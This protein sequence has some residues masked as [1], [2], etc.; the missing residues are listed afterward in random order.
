MSD[1]PPDRGSAPSGGP[2][3]SVTPAGGNVDAASTAATAAQQR[4]DRLAALPPG[5]L[6]DAQ[7][8][9][10]PRPNLGSMLFLTAF[11]FFMSGGNNMPETQIVVGPDGQIK[12]RVT[13][14]DMARTYVDEYKGWMNGTGNWTEVET[15]VLL[16]SSIIP[17]EYQHDSSNS[18]FT[19]ITGFY[20]EAKIHLV[21]LLDPPTS[22]N[23][24]FRQVHLPNLNTSSWNETLA[25]EL[26]GSWDWAGV[27]KWDLNLREREVEG[28]MRDWTWVKGGATLSSGEENID[29]NFFGLHHLANGTYELFA[30]ADGVK[31][32]IRNIPRLYPSHHNETAQIILAELEKEL[33]IQEGNLLLSDIKDDESTETRCPL[34][35]HLSL[36]PLPVGWSSEAIELYESE[37]RDPTG[38]RSSLIRPP[39][40]WDGVGLG[41]VVI[42]DECGWAFGFDRGTGVKIDDFWRKSIDY[43]AFATVCQLVVLVL[44]VRQ[45]EATRTPSTLAKV[46]LW[47]IVIM[48]ISDSWIFS[49]HVVVGIMSDNRASMAM[50][51][52]GFLCLCSAIVFGPRYA[53]LL[54]RIQAPESV[55]PPRPTPSPSPAP[56]S[57]EPGTLPLPAA[58]VQPTPAPSE[59]ISTRARNLFADHP[60]IRW[61]G[62]LFFVFFIF[63]VALVP[64][65]VPFFLF[66]MYSFWI[67]QIW[68]NARRGTSHALDHTFVIG[69]SLGR[70]GL[71]LYAFACPDNVFFIKTT[72]WVWG[73][74]A[75]QWFQIMVM[76]AQE[77]F[78]P[79]FFLPKSFA[80]EELYN[81][82]P[83]LP[84]AD[85]E[86]PTSLSA[87][88]EKTCSICMEEV[89][90]RPGPSSEVLLGINPRRSYALAPCH[91]LFHTK[92]LQ[93]WL[94]IKTICPLCKRSLPPL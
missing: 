91:H 60:G 65:I 88:A 37:M 66:G 79:A 52:P 8:P 59:P 55:I 82:H 68:R 7:T 61:L 50:L 90:T 31:I 72:P 85:P 73:L 75:W 9:V 35:I 17:P 44:L 56:A 77:R 24:F 29:Y 74:V 80:P 3:P 22:D 48:G 19:N 13:E 15:P 87:G 83:L 33:S 81:Y 51:V 76:I 54:H 2:V 21:N 5:V 53:V 58:A 57:T 23:H 78:G 64:S 86:N 4:R 41:G 12:P 36:P 26:R 32:D 10:Q 25:E 16:P 28:N 67:P 14:L 20:R 71:P 40:Y 89:D 69:T 43:A 45:M 92:C 34:L 70:L 18:F 39:N 62:A 84:P 30:K 63:Q 49:A 93:Q 1:P 27:D 42:A 11:F 46:S 38:I 6:M 94:A 47:S